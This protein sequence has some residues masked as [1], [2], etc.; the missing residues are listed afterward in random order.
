MAGGGSAMEGCLPT[1]CLDRQVRPT[2]TTKPISEYTLYRILEQEEHETERADRSAGI[3]PTDPLAMV[4]HV[5]HLSLAGA[6][7]AALCM[8]FRPDHVLVAFV[9]GG[10]GY[11][12]YSVCRAPR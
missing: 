11:L 3:A 10:V 4:D 1:H 9:C 12:L 7:A 2:M 5:L 8:T 6:L